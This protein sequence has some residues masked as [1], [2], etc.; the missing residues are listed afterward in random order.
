MIY[1]YAKNVSLLHN[2]TYFESSYCCRISYHGLEPHNFHKLTWG[3]EEHERWTIGFKVGKHVSDVKSPSDIPTS[4]PYKSTT[5]ARHSSSSKSP[6]REG[7]FARP[8][9]WFEHP[10]G[11]IA[12]SFRYFFYTQVWTPLRPQGS[13]KDGGEDG[14]EGVLLRKTTNVTKKILKIN[15]TNDI[16][17][18]YPKFFKDNSRSKLDE[19]I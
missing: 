9:V 5:R 15:S 6:P 17:I 3:N 16:A 12:T 8:N 7:E 19:N 18:T 11:R 1:E 2:V 13:S 14:Q 10:T 4:R